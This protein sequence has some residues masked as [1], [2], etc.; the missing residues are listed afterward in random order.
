[1]SGDE[2]KTCYSKQLS[3][4][5]DFAISLTLDEPSKIQVVVLPKSMKLF[6]MF[7]LFLNFYPRHIIS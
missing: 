7:Y 5:E 3:C 4:F 6:K 1:M 2:K